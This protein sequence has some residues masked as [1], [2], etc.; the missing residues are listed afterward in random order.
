MQFR[1]L[2]SSRNTDIQV[3]CGVWRRP[4]WSTFCIDRPSRSAGG[5]RAHAEG[6]GRPGRGAEEGAADEMAKAVLRAPCSHAQFKQEIEN[7]RAAKRANSKRRREERKELKARKKTRVASLS[8]ENTLAQVR[9]RQIG[10][11]QKQLVNLTDGFMSL[12][13]LFVGST[14]RVHIRHPAAADGVCCHGRGRRRGHASGGRERSNG[15]RAAGT[16][17]VAAPGRGG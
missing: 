5:V 9:G 13:R 6:A 15:A 16:L 3:P 11:T 10:S 2:V 1:E 17:R 7:E 8:A 12:R 14:G 4:Q